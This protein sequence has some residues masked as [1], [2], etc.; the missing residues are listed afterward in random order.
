MDRLAF[1]LRQGQGARKQRLLLGTEELLR[2]QLV[3]SGIG[4]PQESEVERDNILVVRIDAIESRGEVIKRV[5]VA[6]HHQH[7]AR[8]NSESLRSEIVARLDV[9]LIEFSAFK[10]AL[11][12]HFFRDLEG[13]IGRA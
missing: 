2:F 11:A 3:F 8:S 12:G 9:E 4:A 7:I 10:S 5:V 13:E 6:D 1:L